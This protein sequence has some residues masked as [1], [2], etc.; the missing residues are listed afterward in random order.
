MQR[1]NRK[2]LEL[3]IL[4]ITYNW[5]PRNAIGTHR[6]YSW[7]KY[8][9]AAGNR[10]SVLTARKYSFDSPLDLD[11][12]ALTQTDVFEVGYLPSGGT[13]GPE[14]A[15]SAFRMPKDRSS[16]LKM[17]AARVQPFLPIE[18]SP[19]MLWLRPAFRLGQKIVQQKNINVI[20]ST[21]GPQATHE[22]AYRLKVKYPHL[23][24]V[25]DYRDLWSSQL[26]RQTPPP[27]RILMQRRE[28]RTVGALADMVTT[29]SEGLGRNLRS[30]LSKAT[31]TIE[32]G[33][34]AESF[35]SDFETS[36]SRGPK[37]DRIRIVYTGMIYRGHRDP[38]RLFEAL[39]QMIDSGE[40]G[41]DRVAVEFYGKNQAG[42][43]DMVQF[44]RAEKYT[45]I[46]GHVSH[47]EALEAQCSADL[48]LLLEDRNRSVDGV[49][50][51][52]V[53]EYM[54]SGTPILCLGVG[55][56]AEL[57]KLLTRC[58]V[59]I[60]VDDDVTRIKQTLLWIRENGVPPWYRPDFDTITK[61]SRRFLAEKML[62]TIRQEIGDRC[63]DKL[64]D[65]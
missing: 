23:F 27:L 51:G 43:K 46:Q 53:F 50:T 38:S 39:N 22:I 42:L 19:R 62:Q 48:L 11:L 65:C 34:D 6:P 59:G 16:K 32:N 8:W 20:V 35:G 10:V 3:N 28:I 47:P 36:R 33:F 64:L 49:L 54:F 57:A 7:A 17:L 60:A 52:K 37:K 4:I 26:A 2:L 56:N 55:E 58:G 63:D 24:W 29:V 1:N 9:G 13:R 30:F 15:A 40:M 41:D 44:W 5:P 45:R 21:Y 14:N 61:F 18:L 12:P 25:A 31:Y